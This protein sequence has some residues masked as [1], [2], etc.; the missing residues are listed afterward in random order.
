MPDRHVDMTLLGGLTA[1]RARGLADLVADVTGSRLAG[2]PFLAPVLLYSDPSVQSQLDLPLPQ[3][4]AILVQEFQGV[5][6]P[7]AFPL[8]TDLDAAATVRPQDDIVELRFSLSAAQAAVAHLSTVL[9]RV[10]VTD[11]GAVKA[12]PFRTESLGDS[13][14]WSAPFTVSQHQTDRYLTLSGDRNPIHRDPAE[15]RRLGLTAP[16]VPGLLLVSLIQPICEASVPG[17]WLVSLKSRFLAPLCMLAPLRIGV[18]LRGGALDQVQKARAYL[19]DMDD[20]ALAIVDLQV[21]T[22]PD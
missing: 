12:T 19:I 9:R 22:T 3:G 6:Y 7:A 10:P 15:A 13:V 18:Q 1:N 20:R 5:E 16:I 11:L 8:N 17:G 4:D 14:R 2:P 21:R